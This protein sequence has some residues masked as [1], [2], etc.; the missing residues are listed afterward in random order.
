MLELEG[1]VVEWPPQRIPVILCPRSNATLDSKGNVSATLLLESKR[2]RIPT[3]LSKDARLVGP[4]KYNDIVH[5]VPKLFTFGSVILK[6]PEKGGDSRP[7]A[8]NY[9]AE[10]HSKKRG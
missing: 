5:S 6:S 8:C 9:G 4:Y 1:Q 2:A 7:E 10:K 3:G